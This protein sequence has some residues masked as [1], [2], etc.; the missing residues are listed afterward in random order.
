MVLSSISLDAEISSRIAKAATI[1]SKLN[2]R[3]WS[4]S[5]LTV[6]TKMHVY[7]ACVLSRR[8]DSTAF[9]YDVL[10]TSSRSSGMTKWQIQRSFSVLASRVYSH[11]SARRASVG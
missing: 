9:T 1:M 11:S 2:K 3:V 5:H 6:N 10:H 4:N 7:Q 8:S